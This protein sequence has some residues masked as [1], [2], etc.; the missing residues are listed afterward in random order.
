MNIK[1][2]FTAVLKSFGAIDFVKKVGFH[3]FHWY[4]DDVIILA[5]DVI[6]VVVVTIVDV[7]TSP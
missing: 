6:N 3:L 7:F 1:A 2:V 5:I 4:V